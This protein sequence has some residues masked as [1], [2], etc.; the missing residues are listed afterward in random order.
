MKMQK[1]AKPP[2]IT[3]TN[4]VNLVNQTEIYLF[5]GSSQPTSSDRIMYKKNERTDRKKDGTFF[6]VK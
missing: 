1:I 3:Q 5:G 6:I 4:K 2:S